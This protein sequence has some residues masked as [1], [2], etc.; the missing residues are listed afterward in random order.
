MTK[1]LMMMC[2]LNVCVSGCMIGGA[3]IASFLS[4]LC[5]HCLVISSLRIKTKYL[6]RVE[7]FD[8]QCCYM[9]FTKKCK[10]WIWP[11]PWPPRW[12]CFISHGSVIFYCIATD[13]F[14]YTEWYEVHWI[15]SSGDITILRQM[16]MIADLG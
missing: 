11:S 16:M 4:L 14:Q 6:A 7:W 8:N 13:K 5:G 1:Q 2:T 10:N 3:F 15:Y 12:G 9:V